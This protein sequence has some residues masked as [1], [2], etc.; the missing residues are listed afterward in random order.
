MEL[1]VGDGDRARFH[2]RLASFRFDLR[3]RHSPQ[4]SD[5]RLAKR[6]STNVGAHTKQKNGRS[7]GLRARR[8]TTPTILVSHARERHQT[9]AAAIKFYTCKLDFSL[10]VQMQIKCGLL[11]MIVV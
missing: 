10:I 7:A 5:F 6:Q 2:P 3:L 4:R 9:T 8:L 1:G 11:Q